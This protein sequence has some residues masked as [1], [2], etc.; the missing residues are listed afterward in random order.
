[1]ET[2]RLRLNFD[3][4]EVGE[5]ALGE[6]VIVVEVFG[7]VTLGATVST[8][9]IVV[10]VVVVVD[11]DVGVGVFALFNTI[12][13]CVGV[14]PDVDVGVGVFVR[15]VVFND[16]DDDFPTGV[17]DD[18]NDNDDVNEDDNLGIIIVGD[19]IIL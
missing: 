16:G 11:V 9:T 19:V 15:F 3:V 10:V 1:M 14:D 8:A 12:G 2:G 18:D 4:G 5:V 13:D 7:I 6:V 17:G